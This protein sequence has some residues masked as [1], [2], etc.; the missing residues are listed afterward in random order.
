MRQRGGGTC[1]W[2]PPAR[3]P[4]LTG[5]LTLA[6]ITL[7]VGHGGG[8]FWFPV[9]FVL[10]IFIAAVNGWVLLVEVLR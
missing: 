2:P 6:G 7:V 3:V 4:C 1:S 9:A 8:L 5:S 10:A